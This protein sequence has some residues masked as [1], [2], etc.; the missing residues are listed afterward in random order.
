MM[1]YVRLEIYIIKFSFGKVHHSKLLA[2]IL[3][4]CV[5]LNGFGVFTV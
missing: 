3:A 5:K 1:Q 2:D 4:Q